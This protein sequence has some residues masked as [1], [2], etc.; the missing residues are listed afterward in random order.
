MDQV[1]LPTP[2][3]LCLPQE[4]KQ[5]HTGL[6]HWG[7]GLVGPEW[8]EEAWRFLGKDSLWGEARFVLITVLAV[9]GDW[10]DKNNQAFITQICPSMSSSRTDSEEASRKGE[11]KPLWCFGKWETLAWHRVTLKL[12]WHSRELVT[13]TAPALEIPK[14][15]FGRKKSMAGPVQDLDMAPLH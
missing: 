6:A 7:V 8:C 13:V 11:G 5:V 10:E 2:H 1:S 9:R 3:Q 15:L 4:C 14:N 12:W